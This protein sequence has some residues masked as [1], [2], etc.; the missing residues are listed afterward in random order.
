M[1]GD[2]V[3]AS[4]DVVQTFRS[5]FQASHS[6]MHVNMD[7]SR[8]LSFMKWEV[9]H[10]SCNPKLEQ[11]CNFSSFSCFILVVTYVSHSTAA[12]P[13]RHYAGK[14]PKLSFVRCNGP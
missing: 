3:V 13:F 14:D 11:T 12:S 9:Y 5:K 7:M 8:N 2:G 10:C 6:F 4:K 1:K